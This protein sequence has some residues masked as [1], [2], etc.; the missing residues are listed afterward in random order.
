MEFNEI[1]INRL[2]TILNNEG[3]YLSEQF[4]N[5]LKFKSDKI[6]VVICQDEREKSNLLYV[7]RADNNQ[8]LIDGNII[9][10]FFVPDSEKEFNISELSVEDFANNLF[11]LFTGKGRELLKENS[12]IL[13]DIKNFMEMKSK[14]YTDELLKRQA[15]EEASK[16][17]E[18][19]DYVAFVESIDKIGISKMPQSYQLK[20]KI[21]KQKL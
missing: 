17:W 12:E 9:K 11:A 18:A 5:Y 20:Y 15:L 8:C 10:M 13:F 1:I 6:V 2:G 4:R 7:G 21:A 14:E 3:L 16:A 19:N